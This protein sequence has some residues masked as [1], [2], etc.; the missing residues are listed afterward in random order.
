M[1]SGDLAEITPSGGLSR[2][3]L[4]NGSSLSALLG[5]IV[6]LSIGIATLLSS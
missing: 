4:D 1:I 6:V 2:L 5:V 3:S